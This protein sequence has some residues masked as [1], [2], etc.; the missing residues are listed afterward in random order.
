[1]GTAELVHEIR[2]DTVEVDTV[3]KACGGGVRFGGED[4]KEEDLGDGK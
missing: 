1:M 3:V 4:G 2:D